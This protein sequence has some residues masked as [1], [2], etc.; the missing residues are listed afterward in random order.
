MFPTHIIYLATYLKKYLDDQVSIHFLD[1][2]V[3]RNIHQE[4]D[5]NGPDVIEKV[6]LKKINDDLAPIQKNRFVI[7]ISCFSSYQYIHT[8]MILKSIK[9]LVRQGDIEIPLVVL[10]GYHPTFIP[11]DFEGLGV[12]IIIR[13]EAEI[14]LLE[15]V[16][17]IEYHVHTLDEIDKLKIIDGVPVRNLDMLPMPDFTL[18]GSE[19]EHYPYIAVALSRGCPMTCNFCIEK[20]ASQFGRS[21]LKWRAYSIERAKK[22]IENVIFVTDNYLKQ[23][24]FI[25][26][27]MFG[28]YD[29]IFGFNLKWREKILKFLIERDSGYKIWAET[30]VDSITRE[31]VRLF[32]K[33][34]FSF[35]VGL[36]SASPRMLHLMNKTS[37]PMQYLENFRKLLV[38][39]REIDYGP[40]VLNILCNFPGETAST[41]E[42]TFDYLN[43]LIREGIKFNPAQ[44][45]YKLYP[46]DNIYNNLDYWSN[47]HGFRIYCMNWWQKPETVEYG[48]V[49]D[50]SWKLTFKDAAII[51]HRKMT[52]LYQSLIDIFHDLRY[53]F[54]FLKRIRKQNRELRK[55]MEILDTLMGKRL[56]TIS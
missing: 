43:G 27:K 39:A 56:K 1:F 40:M 7:A 19:L 53:K 46:G 52:A 32:K 3:Q 28:F 23:D 33:S 13:G 17:E 54:H 2:T 5:F 16:K 8:K 38:Y 25:H 45:F 4:L 49:S 10:G 42:E 30:R 35:I 34:N 44:F 14:K 26:E 48:E 15:V 50:A 41:I 12:N 11:E 51:Y 20:K 29:P 9:R 47:T 21:K 37:H 55:R 22:E 36:E 31:Q 18:Y 6:L 24:G